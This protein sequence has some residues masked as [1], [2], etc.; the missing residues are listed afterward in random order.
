LAITKDKNPEAPGAVIVGDGVG[1]MKNAELYKNTITAV[2][3][4][5]KND[6]NKLEY[7]G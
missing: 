7:V 5:I 4:F 3:T 2:K 1:I 6:I